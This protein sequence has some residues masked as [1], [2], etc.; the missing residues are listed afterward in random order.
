LGQ[1][2]R[3]YLVAFAG[4]AF[5]A[6]ALFDLI[7]EVQSQNAAALLTGFFLVYLIEKL[8]AIH[9]FRS[10]ESKRTDM[11]WASLFGVA[12]ESLIDGIAIAIGFRFT[13]AIGI[14]VALTVLIHEIP[15]GFL[16]SVI[17]QRAGYSFRKRWAALLIDAGFAPLGVLLSGV[18]PTTV[19][20]PLAGF[21]AGMFLYIGACDF[22][23]NSH[24]QLTARVVIATLSGATVITFLSLLIGGPL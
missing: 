21:T 16:T 9:A 19:M 13:P 20:D 7:P 8:F 10:T 4:G 24:Q 22:L 11:G 5:V 3:R 15:R 2:E 23:P 6:I 14:L 12:L 1:V 18:F 17:A